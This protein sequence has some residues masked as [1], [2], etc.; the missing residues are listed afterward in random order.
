MIQKPIRTLLLLGSLAIAA[1]LAHA[2][3]KVGTIDMN[4]VFTAYY[5]TKDAET[6]LNEQR[7]AAKKEFDDRVETLKKSM[8]DIEKLNSELEK[9]ELSEDAKKAKL[10]D[11]DEKIAEARNL[12]KEASDF[13]STREKELQEQ[14]LRMRKDIIEDIMTVVKKKVSD[15]GYDLVFDRSGLSMGQIPVL[16]YSAESMDF[17]QSVIKALN[18]DAP[19]TKPTN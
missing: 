8:A 3:T 6:K 10:K 16:V 18:A 2:Q 19:K 9:P 15:A 12:D 17:S 4:G 13:K 14:F 11:R 7:S 5:K 1:P